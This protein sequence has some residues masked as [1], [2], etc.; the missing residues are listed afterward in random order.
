MLSRF[1]VARGSGVVVSL[2]LVVVWLVAARP[3]SASAWTVQL[4]PAP[5]GSTSADLDTVSCTAENACMAIGAFGSYGDEAGGLFA[6]RWN[7]QNWS[8]EPI[9]SPLES[10]LRDVSCTSASACTAVGYYPGSGPDSEAPLV[11]RWN[12]TS[13][14]RQRFRVRRGFGALDSVSCVSPRVCVAV[15]ETD[16]QSLAARWN[17]SRWSIQPTPN[18]GNLQG[19]SC[20]SVSVCAAVGSHPPFNRVFAERW[21][22]RAW[23]LEPTEKPNHG[24]GPSGLS[25]VSC[26]SS[27]ACV[28]VGTSSIGCSECNDNAVGERWSAAGWSL[29]DPRKPVDGG[30]VDV[31]CTST[32]AC[33]AVGDQSGSLLAERLND[34]RWTV[35]P[36]P[37][38]APLIN[39]SGVI[40]QGGSFEGVS[41]TSKSFCIAFGYAT[42]DDTRP[43]ADLGE[44][45]IAIVARYS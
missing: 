11:E 3:A 17:G 32:T 1:G 41:C 30:F 4:A 35:Q 27:F 40:D 9:P 28:A 15:G 44:T 18:G 24:L 29:V 25:A 21:S 13:W 34:A 16:N 26:V 14:S 20:P 42:V 23:K 8:I 37:D 12:G 45:S 38:L 36:I 31:S 33:I 39:Q 43:P 19:V 10:T 6:D 7:G 2:L 22:R 5:A